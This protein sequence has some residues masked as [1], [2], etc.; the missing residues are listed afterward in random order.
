MTIAFDDPFN[1]GSNSSDL[2]GHSPDVG[3]GWSVFSRTASQSIRV[4]TAGTVRPNNNFNDSH[5]AYSAN[6]TPAQANVD[7][8]LD[9]STIP[10]GSSNSVFGLG[11]VVDINNYYGIRVIP[12][13]LVSVY[14]NLDGTVEELVNTTLSLSSTDLITL[15]LR[16]A[17]YSIVQNG[18]ERT[19]PVADTD[20][21]L[22]AG[23]SVLGFGNLLVPTD[24]IEFDWDIGRFRVEEFISNN[25]PTAIPDSTTK[26]AFVGEP[27]NFDL[28]ASTD[29]ETD[30]LT[31][32]V[33]PGDG[34]PQIV[35]PDLSIDH[36]YTEPGIYTAQVFVNDGIQDSP[37]V[38][39]TVVVSAYPNSVTTTGT[40]TGAATAL[41]ALSDD[42][43]ASFVDGS[44]TAVRFTLNKRTG[45]SVRF[46]VRAG[47]QTAPN[48]AP[49][50]TNPGN[51]FNNEG[52]TVSLPI[53]AT[54]ND[55][56]SYS[57]SGLPSGL[58][59]DSVTGVISGVV[60]AGSSALSPY[61]SSVTVTD[62]ITPVT[63]L[64]E[65]NIAVVQAPSGD[66]QNAN[67]FSFGFNFRF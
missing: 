41:D 4:L 7:V 64:F 39:V 35:E 56:L 47:E 6:Y 66:S 12:S 40:V 36:V 5:V 16:G 19:T 21:I 61:N 49:E 8:T 27:V 30:P 22:A 14:K 55:A 2:T 33:T 29:P 10:S 15:R 67:G 28:S 17:E 48:P 38:D 65:W 20:P 24:D 32:K 58:S 9:L 3:A 59:I 50:V 13:G 26:A 43:D 25:P 23:G 60:A 62:G 46:V 31:G 51:R 54:D 42:S 63:V 11:R 37:A 53:I 18:I 45:E 57:A 34:S 52:N 1:A 44:D